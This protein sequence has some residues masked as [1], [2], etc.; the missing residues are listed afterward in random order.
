[1]DLVGRK[2]MDSGEAA[3]ALM[4]ELEADIEAAK[5]AHPMMANAL[6]NAL[7]TLRETTEWVTK[8]DMND[9]FAGAVAYQ[10]AFSRVLGG[11]FH[12]RA[13]LSGDATRINLARFYMTMLLPEH[14]SLCVQ[15]KAGADVLY[16]LEV[17]D[18]AA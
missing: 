18:F 12:L 8:Q 4:D 14:A 17:D 6:W 5:D 13:A 1:M 16:T 11:V 15:A 9:R 10:R 3:F 2:M 7:A